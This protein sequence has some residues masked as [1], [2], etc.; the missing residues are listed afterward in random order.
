MTNGINKVSQTIVIDND[1]LTREKILR[2][3]FLKLGAEI[4]SGDIWVEIDGCSENH[5]G[6]FVQIESKELDDNPQWSDDVFCVFGYENIRNEDGTV[7]TDYGTTA[8]YFEFHK[9]ELI[10]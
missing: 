3:C 6:Y 5:L 10:K 8:I 4:I 9:D 2:D 1:S 7:G